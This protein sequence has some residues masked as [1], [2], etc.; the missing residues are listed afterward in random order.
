M[1][2]KPVQNTVHCN[3]KLTFCKGKNDIL[4]LQMVIKIA[5]LH[6][7]YNAPLRTY[8]YMYVHT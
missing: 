6:K 1:Q 8:I 4:Q 3:K 2:Q 7:A 5:Y